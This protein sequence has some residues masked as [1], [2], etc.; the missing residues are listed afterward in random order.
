VPA[1]LQRLARALSLPTKVALF[2][3]IGALFGDI[4]KVFQSYLEL[5]E[6]VPELLAAFVIGSWFPDRTPAVP[7]LAI[8]GSSVDTLPVLRILRC[9]C[10][11]GL[12]VA[13]LTPAALGSAVMELMPTLLLTHAHLNARLIRLVHA[14]SSPGQVVLVRGEPRELLCAKAISVDDGDFP[15]DLARTALRVPVYPMA[16]SPRLTEAI[17]HNL[18]EKFQNRLFAY[19]LAVWEKVMASDLEVPSFIT[20]TRLLARTLGSCIVDDAEL[21]RKIVDLLEVQDRENRLARSSD[22]RCAVIEAVLFHKREGK[23]L[24]F[25]VGEIAGTVND[26][27]QARDEPV[28]LTERKVGEELKRLGFRKRRQGQGMYLILDAE[29]QQLVERLARQYDVL[30]SQFAR[31]RPP[32]NESPISG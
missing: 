21:Q 9:L 26:L 7:L 29:N 20:E 18:E 6:R 2:G 8:Y 12:I 3:S 13:D 17:L 24:K 22:V 19:R 10:R 4:C 30:S 5:P 14:S 28:K 27:F 32:D 11:R 25:L 31:E 16:R 1:D 23:N 15:E